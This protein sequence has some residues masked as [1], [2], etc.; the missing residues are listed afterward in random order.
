MQSRYIR[1]EKRIPAEKLPQRYRSFSVVTPSKKIINAV[2]ADASMK[3]YGF[4]TKDS[5]GDLGVGSH[6]ELQHSGGEKP[7]HGTVVYVKMELDG[8]R[9]GATLDNKDGYDEYKR[10]LSAVIKD[11]EQRSNKKKL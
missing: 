7:V 11:L 9:I 5:T 10:D 2:T 8:M 1:K 6:I 4:V 3:G